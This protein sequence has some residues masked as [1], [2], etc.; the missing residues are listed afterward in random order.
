MIFRRKALPPDLQAVHG[1]FADQVR[2]MEEARDALMSCLPVGRVDP[3][4]VP[5]GLELLDDVLAELRTELG[6]WRVPPLE[7][8]WQLCVEAIAESRENIATARRIATSST[9]LEQLLG[10]VED[11]DEPLGYAFKQ[12]EL[13]FRSLR[14]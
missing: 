3:A 8:E 2:R 12:A 4:P 11:V 7:G 13:R 9:E 6:G 1:V 5:V 10:A 14:R